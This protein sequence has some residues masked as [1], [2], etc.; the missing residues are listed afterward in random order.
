MELKGAKEEGKGEHTACCQL[1]DRGCQDNYHPAGDLGDLMA[2]YTTCTL[3]KGSVIK[4][5]ATPGC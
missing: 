4:A 2:K 3:L 5:R 1:L